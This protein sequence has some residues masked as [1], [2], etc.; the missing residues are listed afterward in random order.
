MGMG[1]DLTTSSTSHQDPEKT[2]RSRASWRLGDATLPNAARLLAVMALGALLLALVY[3]I[4]VTHTV[5]I[6]GYDSA[7]VQGF[8]D[9][10]RAA[11]LD[12]PALNGSDGSARWTRATSYLLFPQAGLPAQLTLRLRGWR[13]AGPMPN[14][15]VLLNGTTVLDQFRAGAE[16][17]DHTFQ[18]NGG[19][20][21]PSDVVIEIRSE[22]AQIGANDPREVGVLI[23]HAT[24]HSGPAPIIP[25]PPQLLYGALAAGMVYILVMAN[26]EPRTTQRVPDREPTK[27][28]NVERWSLQD[29]PWLLWFISVLVL[30]SGFWV[31]YRAQPPYPYP[32]LRLLPMIDGVL[33]ALLAIRY[34]PALARRVPA[35]LDALSIGGIGV[36]T[37][38]ILVGARQHVTLSLPSVEGDFRVF[39]LRS[40]HLIGQFPA[41]T[42]NPDRD[43]VLRADG[44]YNLGYPL[45]L[46]LA[47]PFTNDN[48]FLAAQLIAALSGALLLL[49]GWWLARR[50]LGRSAALLALLILALSPL[51]VEYALYVGTDMPFAAACALALA[52]LYSATN[53]QRPTTKEPVGRLPLVIGL[54]SF[55]IVLTGLAAGAAFLIRHPGLLL[56]PFGW[57]V[58][59][60][61]KHVELPGE[62]SKSKIQNPKFLLL[63]TLAFLLTI[64][65][66]LYVNLRDTG[67]PLFNQQAKNVWQGVFGDGDWGR[68]A[69]TANDITLGRVIA[70]DP[71]R[72]LA[73]WWANVRGYFGTGGEDTREFGQATQLRLLSFPANWLA[74]IGLLG[75]LF[76]EGKRQKAK[77]KNDQSHLVILSSCH[78]VTLSLLAWIALYVLTIS[79]GLAP[80]VRFFLPLTPIYA[81]AAAWTITRLQPATIG[82]DNGLWHARAIGR[83]FPLIA[84]IV[85]L[86]LLWGGFASGTAYVT[87]VRTPADDNSP[88]QPADEVAAAGLV[89]QTL[90]GD[91]RLVLQPPQGS[92]DGLSLGKY[93]AIADR[94]V[95]A[96]PTDDLAALR[97]TGAGYLLRA[98][99]LGPAPGGLPAIGSAGGYTLYR[100]TR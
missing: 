30:G 100:I 58:I 75:W 97:T 3:Q 41:G 4:P 46:W 81:L 68:W 49:A 23:D 91:E 74:I 5:D 56:L 50:L 55:V 38:A 60:G 51:V 45:L 90:R 93:S 52:L 85:L 95:P 17:E 22:T 79:I 48:P 98:T 21:K 34:G 19:L 24:F 78:L 33:T 1:R 88:G 66:Q 72:F 29:R 77:G 87:R 54:S 35:L 8:F 36:W 64:S 13:L 99:T 84:G 40:A 10:E 9:P 86:A 20:L 27:Q 57:L 47:R 15:Q 63:F 53:D 2:Q 18:I 25:Y 32:L 94:V 26:R 96:P 89:L 39:A 76:E 28:S 61:V 67:S 65:P 6:G 31:L 82:E 92:L 42:N 7:Y 69:A 59:L 44:F 80:Q 43:G 16:W 70:Q 62:N 37:A 83:N 11:G 12:H 71:A 73:N 14:V